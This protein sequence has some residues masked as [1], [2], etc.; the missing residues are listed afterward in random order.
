[1]DFVLSPEG[2]LDPKVAAVLAMA[3]TQWAKEYLRDWRYT[4][5]LVLGI[6][7]GVEFLATAILGEWDLFGAAMAAFWGASLATFGY[8]AASN[9]LGMAGIGRR[10][11]E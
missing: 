8:E 6:T 4:Q 5:L 7:L 9:W 1:M 10:A 2:L 11:Q 3:L